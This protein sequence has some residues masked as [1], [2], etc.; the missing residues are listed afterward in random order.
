MCG[1]LSP[2]IRLRA[3]LQITILLKLNNTLAY[4]LL[5]MVY[6]NSFTPHSSEVSY[7]TDSI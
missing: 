2:P 5:Y 1:K 4:I 3:Q 7:A 6:I